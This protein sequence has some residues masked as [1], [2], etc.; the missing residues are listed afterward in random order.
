MAGW[1][2]GNVP[3]PEPHLTGMSAGIVLHLVMGWR[4][5]PSSVVGHTLGWPLVLA[6]AGLAVWAVGAAGRVDLARPA[7]I[8]AAGPYHRSRNPMYMAWT[9]LY[10]GIALAV[11]TAWPFAL[12][13]AVLLW[14]HHTVVRE[15]RDLAGRFGAAYREYVS[16]TRR[17]V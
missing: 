7:R 14:M 10:A 1:R 5:F 3:L 17:Y 9:L 6:G 4:L 16:R 13:P 12:L 15:E 2:W 11:N 8:V